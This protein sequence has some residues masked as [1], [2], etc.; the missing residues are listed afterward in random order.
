MYT[1]RFKM[2]KLLT[3]A[4]LLLT[5]ILHKKIT[6]INIM[7]LSWLCDRSQDSQ[8]TTR[9][10]VLLLNQSWHENLI[11]VQYKSHEGCENAF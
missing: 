8:L 4:K 7:V 11:V 9:S 5:S 10:S 2:R 6:E 1:K 3:D